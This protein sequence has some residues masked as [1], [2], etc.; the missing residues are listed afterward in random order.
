MVR[1]PAAPTPAL[2]RPQGARRR[3]CRL[4]PRPCGLPCVGTG[5]PNPLLRLWKVVARPCGQQGCRRPTAVR[6]RCRPGLAALSL[7]PAA[8]CWCA[9]PWCR[10]RGARPC[11]LACVPTSSGKRS[12][13]S[14]SRAACGPH[15]CSAV[16]SAGTSAIHRRPEH[17]GTSAAGRMPPPLTL[18][19][20]LHPPQ[21]ITPRQTPSQTAVAAGGASASR[22]AASLGD[23]CAVQH[24]AQRHTATH[25]SCTRHVC[26]ASR[27]E[28]AVP[29]PASP[30]T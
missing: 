7:F 29:G 16:A 5:H 26:D 10:W 1:L 28:T 11:L 22:C 27:P 19:L 25:V 21:R 8:R 23:S 20:H 30:P 9:P 18:Y 12:V 2:P 24:T 6:N 15:G 14:S 13:V 3:G 17:G 4:L